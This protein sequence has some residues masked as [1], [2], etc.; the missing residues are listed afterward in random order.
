[1]SLAIATVPDLLVVDLDGFEVLRTVTR[2]PGLRNTKKRVVSAHVYPHHRTAARR[3]G[4]DAFLAKPMDCRQFV[5]T[6][7]SLITPLAK[8]SLTNGPRS[9]AASAGRKLVS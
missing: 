3:A 8:A 6:A 9:I 5:S 1:M 7:L 2:H 4:G